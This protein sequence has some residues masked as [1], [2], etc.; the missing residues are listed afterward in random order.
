VAIVF[1]ITTIVFFFPQLSG[2]TFFWEDFVEYVY[3]TQ[4][5][6][7][8]AFAD[9]DIPVWNPYVFGG[10]PFIADLQV[11]FFYPFNRLLSL[12][13]DSDGH[14]SH[15]WL[16]AIVILHFFIAQLGMYLFCR[17]L[18]ISSYSS[19][20]PAVSFAF[21]S[22]MVMHVIHPMVVFHLAWLPWATWMVLR[23]ID[24]ADFKYAGIAGIILGGSFLA[25]HPQTALYEGLF[26]GLMAV[27]RWFDPNNNFDHDVNRKWQRFAAPITA[28]LLA[29]GI[30]AIQ[31]LPTQELADNAKR[32]EATYEYVT[33]GSMQTSD[34][35]K[36]VIPEIKGKLDWEDR[37]I[38]YYDTENG[39]LVNKSFFYW[40]KSLYVGLAAL[41]LGICG[42]ILAFD[43]PIVR[44][45]AAFSV[46]GI[47][48][49]YGSNGFVFD[50]FYNLPL[51]DTFRF[52]IRMMFIVMFCFSI[53]AGFAMDRLK[54]VTGSGANKEVIII[55]NSV[56]ALVAIIAMLVWQGNFTDSLQTPDQIRSS[57][58]SYAGDTLVWCLILGFALAAVYFH[59]VRNGIAISIVF[60]YAFF[61][62]YMH[63]AGFNSYPENRYAQYDIS[64]EF[65][66][67]FSVDYPND[68][69]R[70]NSRLYQPSYMALQRNQGLID[71]IMLLEGYNPL[72]L[73]RI[74]PSFPA[75]NDV[76]GSLNVRFMLGIDKA[77]GRP[78]FYERRNDIAPAWITR[79]VTLSS[80]KEETQQIMSSFPEGSF[81]SMAVIE[82]E[83]DNNLP[84]IDDI[85]SSGVSNSNNDNIELIEY[86]DD[87]ISYNINSDSEGFLI[88]S[89]IFYP[90]WNA[91][92]DGEETEMYIANG[93]LR[94]IKIGKG[95]FDIE[96]KYESS[97][98]TIG[99]WLSFISLIVCSVLII[100]PLRKK[101]N[102]L[103]AEK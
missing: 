64:P 23:S 67:A 41:I 29:G 30:F 63:G 56:L 93:S 13:V 92:I 27:W 12:F 25:G 53:A 11:G 3:P 76:F 35:A 32:S 89:E 60:L 71:N 24:E 59:K 81:T 50:I 73:N 88:F 72:Q 62:L 85:D 77:T 94:A 8:R 61:D 15:W 17:Y 97:A 44:F 7:A 68:V 82:A 22:A 75:E 49:A 9:G 102:A 57:I 51:F 83:P 4:T 48:F 26:L 79:D 28:F 66:S 47:L 16:Q 84:S 78:R 90:A 86:Q 74:M 69:F 42:F 46:L 21:C 100:I 43:R 2:E 38:F 103:N 36:L 33:E 31:L 65:A 20:I 80:S 98:L 58:Q 87:Y 45:L 40:E 37:N 96:L 91:Y 5:Y 95:K 55:V 1:A 18:K 99:A 54:N 101:Q 10:M 6:A 19:L 52:P 70:V 14:L 39:E 34:M